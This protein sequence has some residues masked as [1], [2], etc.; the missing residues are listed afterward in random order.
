MLILIMYR[1]FQL[2]VGGAV[3]DDIDRIRA[4]RDMLDRKTEE[5]RRNGEASLHIPLL[6]DANT[7]I[8]EALEYALQYVI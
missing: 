4:V 3:H 8:V 1:I 2:K 7:G 6:C 5:L